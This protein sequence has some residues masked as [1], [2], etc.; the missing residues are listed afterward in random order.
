[1]ERISNCI[2]G[3]NTMNCK[4]CEGLSI[5]LKDPKPYLCMYDDHYTKKL[6]NLNKKC[7]KDGVIKNE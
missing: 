7:P 5:D 3:D 1:M 4:E 6:E 2:T